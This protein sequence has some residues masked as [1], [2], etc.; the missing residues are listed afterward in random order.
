M[1]KL[2]IFAAAVMG[3]GLVSCD[4]VDLPNPPA[5]SNPQEALFDKSDLEVVAD[6]AAANEVYNL[7]EYQNQNML[8]PLADIAK[9]ENVPAGGARGV[10][11]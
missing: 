6:P 9:M 10:S 8:V 1:K 5:Q 11:G 3:L 7:T 4:Q 2:F